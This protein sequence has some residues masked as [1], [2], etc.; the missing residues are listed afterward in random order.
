MAPVRRSP[1][2]AA[3]ALGQSSGTAPRGNGRLLAG[4][5]QLWIHAPAHLT[6]R[7][8]PRPSSSACSAGSRPMDAAL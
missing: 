4:P 5:Q 7:R 2:T 8:R 3:G 6:L 1:M